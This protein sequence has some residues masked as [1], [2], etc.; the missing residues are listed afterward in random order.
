M[1]RG[2]RELWTN[3]RSERRPSAIALREGEESMSRIQSFHRAD[4]THAPPSIT[5]CSDRTDMNE[6]PLVMI[7]PGEEYVRRYVADGSAIR[8]EL[9]SPCARAI[10]P[11]PR[12]GV[13]A[14][15]LHRFH[16]VAL[17]IFS[18]D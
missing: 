1:P 17:E 14:R 16:T 10:S 8:R 3:V 15:L 11:A 2:K 5:L 18:C 7:G 9:S 13:I 12:S 6:W 4:I